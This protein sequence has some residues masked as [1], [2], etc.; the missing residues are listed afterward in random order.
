MP[1]P[2]LL[3]SPAGLAMLLLRKRRLL[4]NKLMLPMLLLLNP[5]QGV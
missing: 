2:L 3:V 1:Q 4:V 5:R